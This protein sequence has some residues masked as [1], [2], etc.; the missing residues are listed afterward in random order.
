MQNTRL[1]WAQDQQATSAIQMLQQKTRALNHNSQ[2][3]LE[4]GYQNL[5]VALLQYR[6]HA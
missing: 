5:A 3:H 1:I 4:R 6:F 2:M